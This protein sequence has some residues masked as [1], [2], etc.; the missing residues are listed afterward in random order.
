MDRRSP[1]KAAIVWE[2]GRR[3]FELRAT[4]QIALV[5]PM[6]GP[7]EIV[8][9]S[10]FST[11]IDETKALMEADPAIRAGIFVFETRPW[12]SFPGNALPA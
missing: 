3:N 11:G 9:M 1:E 12:I 7:G 2:H 5:G 6:A 10:V 8:G 4:G